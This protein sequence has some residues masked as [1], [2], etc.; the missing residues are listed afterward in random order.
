MNACGDRAHAGAGRARV[1]AAGLRSGRGKGSRSLAVAE[2]DASRALARERG[3]EARPLGRG[4]VWAYVRK[5][6]EADACTGCGHT[7]RTR[8]D[9]GAGLDFRIVDNF[10]KISQ[11]CAT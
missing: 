11:S 6:C 3:P 10:I 2:E 7:C 1:E 9:T 4:W 5:A 8:A